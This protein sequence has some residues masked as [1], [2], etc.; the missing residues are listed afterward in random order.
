[1]LCARIINIARVEIDEMNDEAESDSNY[2]KFARLSHQGCLNPWSH[3]VKNH[4]I[5]NNSL[6]CFNHSET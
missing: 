4:H 6:G 3:Y 1:M 2:D 5:L